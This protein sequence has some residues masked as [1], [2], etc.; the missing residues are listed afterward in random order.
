MS[1]VHWTTEP[2]GYLEPKVGKS[3]FAAV[4]PKTVIDVFQATVA[5]HGSRKA[6]LL[7]RGSEVS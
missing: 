5:K 6:L 3:G 7:K 1:G 4:E 2:T